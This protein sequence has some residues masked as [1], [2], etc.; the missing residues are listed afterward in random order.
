MACF[1]GSNVQIVIG[2]TSEGF[3]E[4][5]M[6]NVC[7]VLNAHRAQ[8]RATQEMNGRET[9]ISRGAA[10]RLPIPT[11]PILQNPPNGGIKPNRHYFPNLALPALQRNGV[12][13]PESGTSHVLSP[14]DCWPLSPFL[15]PIPEVSA[16]QEWE[17]SLDS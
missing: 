3:C 12:K 10:A 17:Q 6:Q 5:T 7:K 11:T 15:T 16:M 14:R 1:F 13:L 4:D 9:L 2:A 8:Q